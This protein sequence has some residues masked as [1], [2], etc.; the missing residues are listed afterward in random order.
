MIYFAGWSQ[1]YSIYP[2]S[3]RLVAAFKDALTRYTIS[4]GTIRFPL[5]EPVPVKL[6]ERDREVPRQGSLLQ[7]GAPGLSARPCQKSPRCRTRQCSPTSRPKPLNHR[8]SVRKPHV[9]S[10]GTFR[11]PPALIVNAILDCATIP[12]PGCST[13]APYRSDR[14]HRRSTA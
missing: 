12:K 2:S 14:R 6:I 1:H 8:A 3:D 11:P 4:K 10:I 13:G 9:S 7:Q 5:S